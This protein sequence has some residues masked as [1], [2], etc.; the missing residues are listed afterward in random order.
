MG[1]RGARD[2]C[3]ALSTARRPL[4]S[5]TS[6]RASCFPTSA[7]GKSAAPVHLPPCP[8]NRGSIAALDPT[9]PPAA[10]VG[11]RIPINRPPKR[12]PLV[13]NVFART[14]TASTMAPQAAREAGEALR[15]GHPLH[16]PGAEGGPA[17][18]TRATPGGERS[19]FPTTAPPPPAS[20]LSEVSLT[21]A[22]WIQPAYM[23]CRETPYSSS[24]VDS[25]D[26]SSW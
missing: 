11:R 24:I 8:F 20:S 5:P 4:P 16:D 17:L 21:R 1:G 26:S 2:R 19:W 9:V 25:T 22:S 6:T 18:E 3:V 10:D 14:S 12:P 7:P 15:A 13:P 23:S